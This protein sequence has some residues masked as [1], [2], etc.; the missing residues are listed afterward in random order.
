MD[1]KITSWRQ[2]KKIKMKHFRVL[3]SKF[4][5]ELD[6]L[7][8]TKKKTKDDWSN[9]SAVPVGSCNKSSLCIWGKPPFLKYTQTPLV[10]HP[11]VFLDFYVKIQHFNSVTFKPHDWWGKS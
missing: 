8:A 3:T 7:K 5:N 9:K 4:S 2:K 10:N 6:S 1:C 11:V